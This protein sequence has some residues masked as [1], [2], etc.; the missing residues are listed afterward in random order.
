M[1]QIRQPTIDRA[2]SLVDEEIDLVETERKAF[3]R[4][5]AR[6]RDVQSTGLN[7]GSPATGGG[8]TA[9]LAGETTA[10]DE[11]HQIQRAYRETVMAVPHYEREY[12]DTLRESLTEELGGTLA[13]HVVDG[14]VLTPGIHD[15]LVGVTEQVRD[16]R[17]GFLRQLRRERESL[18]TVAEQLNDVEA[19]LMELDDRI[20][21]T[22]RSTRLAALDETLERLERRC[23]DLA[24]RR[25]EQIHDRRAGQLSGVDAA[26]LAGY[27]YS[28]LGTD[29][30]AL[31]DIASRLDAVRTHR[32]RCLR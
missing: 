7:G 28:D 14:Q 25:Q 8:P 3:E 1:V 20:A 15:A 27:L 17:D 9:L 12:G 26:S 6:L 5:L 11:L 13:S 19:R 4:F 2:L 16:D 21:A 24:A 22:T 18:R 31:A 32:T 29:T 23:A 30:P 10:A